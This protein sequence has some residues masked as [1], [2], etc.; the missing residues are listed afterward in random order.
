[1]SGLISTIKQILSGDDELSDARKAAE[2]EFSGAMVGFLEEQADRIA[3]VATTGRIPNDDFW[4][5][6]D[7][8]LSEFLGPYLLQWS[9]DGIGEAVSRLASVG[10]GVGDEVNADAGK[11]AASHAKRL[12][13]SI[14]RT[15]RRLADARLAILL[16][17]R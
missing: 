11:W 13:K 4:L 10:L 3:L 15:S 1:M 16:G 12:G 14:N 8:L 5:S 9:E 17:N 7:D 6:E 2:A